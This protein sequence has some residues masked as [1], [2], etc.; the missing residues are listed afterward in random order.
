MTR[1]FQQDGRVAQYPNTTGS[2]ILSGAVVPMGH[3]IGIALQDIANN[4]TGPVAIEGVFSGIPKVTTAVLTVG[5]KLLWDLSA[6]KFDAASATPASGD[7]MGAY[8][9]F[10]AAGNGATTC[11]IKLT[12]GNATLTP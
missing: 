9:A 11:T 2:T 12:P 4:A 10:E 7:I 1:K 8:I 6:L 3:T 5:A